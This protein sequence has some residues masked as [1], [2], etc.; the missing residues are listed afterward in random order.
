MKVIKII[1]LILWMMIIFAF[2]NQKAIDSSNLS[3]GLIDRTVVKVY[4]VFYDD[5]SKEKEEVIIEKYSY[6]IRK[7]A[8]YSLYFILGILSFL[9][10]VDYKNN[11]KLIL[12]SMLICFLYACTDEFHQLFVYGRGASLKDVKIDFIGGVIGSIFYS[13]ISLRTNLKSKKIREV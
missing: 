3:N 6:P 1:L 9:V 8:H 5:I 13:L 2:S 12:Y 11:K 10:I 7:L 4:K